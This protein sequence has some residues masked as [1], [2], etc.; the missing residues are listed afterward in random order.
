MS[1]T[2]NKRSPIC[3][4][5]APQQMLFAADRFHDF[6]QVP[7]VVRR[8]AIP[9]DAV[10]EMSSKAIDPLPDRF[11]T[12]YQ[13]SHRRQVFNICRAQREAMIRPDR[14]SND[15][16]GITEA[17]QARHAGRNVHT[18]MLPM[19]RLLDNLAIPLRDL[20]DLLHEWPELDAVVMIVLHRRWSMIRRLR[21]VQQRSGPMPVIVADMAR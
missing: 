9:T 19:A 15:P 18:G 14:I 20:R 7:L 10:R 4:D 13:A 3:V 16:A 5:C 6:V 17:F 1:K 21:E 12:G 11:P 2:T 8:W